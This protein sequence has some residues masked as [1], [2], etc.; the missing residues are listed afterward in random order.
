MADLLKRNVERAEEI[1]ASCKRKAY[2]AFGQTRQLSK[3]EQYG[4]LFSWN[5]PHIEFCV[6]FQKI[7]SVSNIWDTLHL[8]AYKHPNADYFLKTLDQLYVLTYYLPNENYLQTGET[9]LVSVLHMADMKKYVVPNN[10]NVLLGYVSYHTDILLDKYKYVGI[11][12]LDT[13]CR[14]HRFAEMMCDAVL[15]ANPGYVL[16]PLSPTAGAARY[17]I[18][19]NKQYKF[20][21]FLRDVVDEHKEDFGEFVKKKLQWSADFVELIYDS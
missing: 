19:Q 13:M 6:N 4:T 15:N 9:S 3:R 2:Y 7:T 21:E 8:I 20:I 17:W 5:S 16:I 1:I 18:K 12:M 10:Y 14:G 11:D